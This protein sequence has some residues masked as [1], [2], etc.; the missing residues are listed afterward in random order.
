[1][2]VY[3]CGPIQGLS[4]Q[5][6]TGWRVTAAET[7]EKWG[8]Q[9][10]D[11]MRGKTE[12]SNLTAIPPDLTGPLTSPSAIVARDY[13]DVQRADLLLANLHG[14]LSAG[15]SAELAWAYANK[16]PVI[17]II[18]AN[19]VHPFIHQ[20]VNVKCECMDDAL[21]AVIGFK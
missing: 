21:R 18:G 17:G 6:A 13:W 7:L 3:L 8:I 19:W 20:F 2:L 1:M 12:L 15:S 14:R 16:K 4:Y 5:E 11:P 9:T 10:L